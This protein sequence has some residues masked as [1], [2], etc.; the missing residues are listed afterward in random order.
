[1]YIRPSITEG[2]NVTICNLSYKFFILSID[3]LGVQQ[4]FKLRLN[5]FAVIKQ[6]N[7]GPIRCCS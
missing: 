3:Q 1:M 6:L 7:K 2:I 4:L 5:P